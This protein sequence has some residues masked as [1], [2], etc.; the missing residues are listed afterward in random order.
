MRFRPS[1]ATAP[2]GRGAGGP[3]PAA[4][5]LRPRRGRASRTSTV[6]RSYG[7]GLQAARPPRTSSPPTASA[8]SLIQRHRVRPERRRRPAGRRHLLRDRR[9]E[10]ALR[11][12]RARSARPRASGV[13]TGLV[14]HARTATASRS[15]S[16]RRR[17]AP[18][19]TADQNVL[20]TARPVGTDANG[21]AA[22]AP[23]ASSCARP[24]RGSSR[25][26]RATLPPNCSFVVE[27]PGRTVPGEQGDP[28]PVDVRR[29]RRR[30]R[31]LRVVLR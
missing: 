9:R 7:L 22:T 11:R 8:P 2:C 15:S 21:A 28:V 18:T 1:S 30:D 5:R 25:R 4:E 27:P 14:R 12:H 29:R 24:S 13:G 26:S 20:V 17:R 3:A 10:R 16:T 31:A 19:A 23:C 6:R